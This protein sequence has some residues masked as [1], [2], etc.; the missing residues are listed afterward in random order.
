MKAM[1][2][3]D[4][5][6]SLELM[7]L[8]ISKNK[9]LEVI[10][11]HTNPK[12]V[13]LDI[14]EFIP[15]VIFVDIEM[16]YMSGL[17]LASKVMQ[18][19]SDIQ[20]VFV[21]AYEQYALKA[22][23]VNAVN[24]ILKPITEESLDITV[25][26]LLKNHKTQKENIFL[27][28]EINEMITFGEFTVYGNISGQK[29]QWLTAKAKELFGYFILQ[30]GKEVDKWLLCDVLFPDAASKN[31]EHSLHSTISRMK[32]ALKKV[33]IENIITCIKGKYK[34]DLTGFTCDLWLWGE[35]LEN[36]PMVTAE[37]LSGYI[38]IIALYTGELFQG[39][40]YLWGLSTKE[41]I[42][43]E[44]FHSLNKIASYYIRLENYQEAVKYLEEYI[45]VEPYDEDVT[46]L[47]IRTYYFIGKRREMT[48]VYR[49]L[50][51]ILQE[52]LGVHPRESLE[53]TYEELLVKL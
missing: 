16:P 31:A 27:E 23:D 24:Y 25:N 14:K 40:D 52:E 53:K 34:L 49:N 6:P 50:Q 5:I 44:Y 9:H 39:E 28:N 3:D 1:L 43:K 7:K 21:T 2:I 8:M 15:D 26:R 10:G 46:E 33:G 29:I 13:L 45:K 48:K 12:E 4:E 20:I 51:T 47:L 41:R 36:N 38:G 37:N 19:N 35:F 11:A 42:N 18:F 22:F 30:K 32:A 17:E